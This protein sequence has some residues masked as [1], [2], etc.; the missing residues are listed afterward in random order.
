MKRIGVFCLFLGFLPFLTGCGVEKEKLH[1]SWSVEDGPSVT[2]KGM[3]WE[4]A[5][6]GKLRLGL[7]V[8]GKAFMIDAGTWSVSGSILTIK[9]KDKDGKEKEGKARIKELTD[10]KLVLKDDEQPKDVILKKVK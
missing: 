6:D 5:A 4:F 9:G 8:D 7:P 1:G 3:V 10:D 2:P